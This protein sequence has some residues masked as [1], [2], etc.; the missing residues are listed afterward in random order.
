MPCK[1]CSQ[2]RIDTANST[3]PNENGNMCGEKHYRLHTDFSSCVFRSWSRTYGHRFHQTH[4]GARHLFGLFDARTVIHSCLFIICDI[5]ICVPVHCATDKPT[6][7]VRLVWIRFVLGCWLLP[8]GCGCLRKCAAQWM[9]LRCEH[10]AENTDAYCVCAINVSVSDAF[11]NTL[12][13]IVI[14]SS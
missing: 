5:I 8:I 9:R 14:L 10:K 12:S 11:S 4:H 7:C 3:K 1:Y 13:L 2:L 6:L